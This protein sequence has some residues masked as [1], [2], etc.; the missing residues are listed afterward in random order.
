MQQP[1]LCSSRSPSKL[2]KTAATRMVLSVVRT[3][4]SFQLLTISLSSFFFLSCWATK[5]LGMKK[6]QASY[7]ERGNRQLKN[8]SFN[9]QLHINYIRWE[10][11]KAPIWIPQ[12]KKKH[13]TVPIKD[14]RPKTSLFQHLIFFLTLEVSG[15]RKT[16]QQV[17]FCQKTQRL[18][19]EKNS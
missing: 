15:V 18:R 5:I 2:S 16:V 10:P 8:P 13:C 19:G 12:R 9:H 7:L 17:G 14:K 3:W 6:K 11:V 1:C 4:T